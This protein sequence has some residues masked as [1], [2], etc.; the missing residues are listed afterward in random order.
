MSIQKAGTLTPFWTDATILPTQLNN[1][2][3]QDDKIGGNKERRRNTG[4]GYS[5]T[6]P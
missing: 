2:L 1:N 5:T 6:T 3:A 4:R